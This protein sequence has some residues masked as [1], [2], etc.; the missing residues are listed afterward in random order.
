MRT[1]TERQYTELR[2]Y[3]D[4][5]WRWVNGGPLQSLV[6]NGL[7]APAAHD[8]TMYAITPAGS[9][10]LAAFRIRYKLS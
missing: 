9:E 1:I 4:H 8:R 10:A 5:S 2:E 3:E 7:I 6:A